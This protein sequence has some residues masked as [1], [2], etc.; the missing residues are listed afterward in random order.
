MRETRIELIG[1]NSRLGWTAFDLIGL[2]LTW[3]DS[4]RLDWIGFDLKG[5]DSTL[6]DTIRL[7]FTRF[8]FILLRS[9]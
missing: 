4:I 2:D 9:T 5:L 8:Y 1:L 3:L 6:L 7:D